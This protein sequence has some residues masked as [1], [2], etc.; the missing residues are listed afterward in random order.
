LIEF[1]V[2]NAAYTTAAIGV[3]FRYPPAILLCQWVSE[4]VLDIQ[5]C[6][7]AFRDHLVTYFPVQLGNDVAFTLSCGA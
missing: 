1:R 2:H 6:S 3:S 7:L 4:A 5:D